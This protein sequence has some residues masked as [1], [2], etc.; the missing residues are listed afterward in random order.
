MASVIEVPCVSRPLDKT[1]RVPGSKSLTNRALICAALG[2]G[3][4]VLSGCLD[5]DDTRYMVDGLRGL[6]YEIEVDGDT[7]RV[8]GTGRAPSVDTELYV[9]AS[10]TCMRFLTALAAAGTGRVSIKGTPRLHERPMNDLL[11]AL[12]GLGADVES[13]P[14][15]YPPVVVHGKGLKGG[16]VD[17]S[18]A[19]S[20]QFISALLMV[21]PMAE[22]P[23]QVRITG[24]LVSRPFVDLTVRLMGE[25]GM[26]VRDDG[27]N[28]YYVPAPQAYRATQH[29][30]EGDAT[31]ASYF[32]AAAAILGGRCRITNLGAASAQGDAR[33][34]RLLSGMGC[35][36]VFDPQYIE[37]RRDPAK[38]LQALPRR[39]TD[40]N[41]MPDVVQTLAAITPFAK[42]TSS[43]INIANLRLKETDRIAAM[44]TELRRLGAGVEEGV[45][46]LTITGDGGASLHPAQVRTYEDHR[47]AM[48]L[49][50]IGLRVPGVQIEEPDVVNKTFP[51]YW[52]ALKTL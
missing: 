12:A 52:D 6:G 43:L 5:S 2:D 14:G 31:A 40:L 47:M 34:A 21:A 28:L 51:G 9:G 30:V 49:A 20:S 8:K 15:G 27:W 23:L 24:S 29:T 11:E 36:S 7:R 41:N 45:D 3:E 1:M 44:A 18:G 19:I 33:F 37:V 26:A 13:A 46:S 4:S 39:L 50:L 17:V 38:P 10:G 25:F 35:T 42:G 48:S 22:Q 32:L 16:A